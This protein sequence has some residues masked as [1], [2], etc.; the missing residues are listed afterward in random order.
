MISH[1]PIG[2]ELLS[3]GDMGE[4]DYIYRNDVTMAQF[5]FLSVAR[6]FPRNAARYRLCYCRN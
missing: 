4:L 3:M 2:R 5:V 1:V 6:N